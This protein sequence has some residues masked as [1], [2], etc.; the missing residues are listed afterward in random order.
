M[1]YL[2]QNRD[3]ILCPGTEL[4][5]NKNLV[6]NLYNAIIAKRIDALYHALARQVSVGA[7]YSG[8]TPASKAVDEGSIPSAPARIKN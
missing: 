2:K 6:W 5:H 7:S 1:A 4:E 3:T 8:S